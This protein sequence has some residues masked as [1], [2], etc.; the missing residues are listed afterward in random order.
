MIFYVCRASDRAAL[1]LGLAVHHRLA[2]RPQIL[3]VRR[4]AALQVDV[5]VLALARYLADGDVLAPLAVLDDVGLGGEAA[6]L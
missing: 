2:P 6:H 3:A 5:G 4:I 1:A